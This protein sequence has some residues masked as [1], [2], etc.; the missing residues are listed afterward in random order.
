RVRIERSSTGTLRV[1]G[2]VG[3]PRGAILNEV[4]KAWLVDALGFTGDRAFTTEMEALLEVRANELVRR[5]LGD[6]VGN[7]FVADT[8]DKGRAWR[9]RLAS[10][11]AGL[12][13]NRVLFPAG[14]TAIIYNEYPTTV[15]KL[16]R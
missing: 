9:A 13:P 5:A 4:I 11:Q 2:P 6:A 1:K 8:V 7:A 10:I 15:N 16:R 12:V 3:A 14:E